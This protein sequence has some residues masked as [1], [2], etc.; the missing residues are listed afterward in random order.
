MFVIMNNN[1]FWTGTKKDLFIIVSKLVFKHKHLE[2]EQ[3]QN[4]KVK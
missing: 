4:I 1:K 3:L 2:V